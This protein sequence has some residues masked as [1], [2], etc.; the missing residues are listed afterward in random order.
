MVLEP[1][2]CV[3][4]LTADGY[5]QGPWRVLCYV[6]RH[7]KW[8]RVVVRC[9]DNGG[10]GQWVSCCTGTLSLVTLGGTVAYT[11]G[12]LQ[13]ALSGFESFGEWLQN[14][15]KD[16]G[17]EEIHMSV[18]RERSW[19][20]HDQENLHYNIPLIHEQ[21]GIKQLCLVLPV[22]LNIWACVM[23]VTLLENTHRGTWTW[24][25]RTYSSRKFIISSTH[26]MVVRYLS[27]AAG[28]LRHYEPYDRK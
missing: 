18:E 27:S 13:S 7:W 6:E 10:W 12:L 1:R 21:V 5:L 4:V 14:S 28:R 11:C 22:K 2:V 24:N 17:R 15:N 25:S 26:E 16:D 9:A 23:R 19:W 3:S 20:N 8:G